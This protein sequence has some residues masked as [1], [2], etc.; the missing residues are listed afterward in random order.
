MISWRKAYE[1]AGY[2]PHEKTPPEVERVRFFHAYKAGKC[3]TFDT[4]EK[5]LKFS[6]NIEADF[7]KD[8]CKRWDE[9]WASRK[10]KETAAGDIWRE[11][12][13]EEYCHLSNEVY[14]LCYSRA[15][16]EAHSSGYDD[17][18]SEMSEVV[19][20]VDAILKLTGAG[21]NK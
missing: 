8:S 21:A 9:Y 16:E 10:A 13:R 14:N 17:I 12:L 15:Y 5:A 1:L 7:T 19:E 11:A 3:E 20:F 18:A 2:D 6:P 4:K